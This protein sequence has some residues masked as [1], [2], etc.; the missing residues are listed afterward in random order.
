MSCQ[1]IDLGEVISLSACQQL[2]PKKKR[3]SLNAAGTNRRWCFTVCSRE[4]TGLKQ[5]MSVT[6]TV[7]VTVDA[8]VAV[9]V[10]GLRTCKYFWILVMSP[11]R[12]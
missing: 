12:Q 10:G 4:S 9:V 2:T 11:S 5:S 8:A 1:R 3:V 7:A 6:V